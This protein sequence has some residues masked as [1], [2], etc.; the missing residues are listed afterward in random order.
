MIFRS[1]K[2]ADVAMGVNGDLI[3]W[4]RANPLPFT[5]AVIPGSQDDLNLSILAESNRV[6]QGKSGANDIINIAVVYPDG[7]TYVLTQGTIT[8]ATFGKSV[9]G[10][11]RMKTRA[12][13]FAFQNV[14]I[15]PATV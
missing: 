7:S 11:G 15:T 14:T 2:I 10:E 6:G 8:D 12:Y 1:I 4:N 3:K 9:A 5:V 13:A